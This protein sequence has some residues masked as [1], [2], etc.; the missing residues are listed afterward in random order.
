MKETLGSQDIDLSQTKPM[1][2]ILVPRVDIDGGVTYWI[3]AVLVHPRIEAGHIYV[4]NFF[5]RCF[6]FCV[7]CGGSSTP[8]EECI[9]GFQWGRDSQHFKKGFQVFVCFFHVVKL[10]FPHFFDAVARGA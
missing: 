10:T 1:R 6:G 2:D 8:P 4:T 9:S 5:L 7:E 3:C